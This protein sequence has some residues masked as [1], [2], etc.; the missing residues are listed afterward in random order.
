M[1]ES[2]ENVAVLAQFS[3]LMDELL[4]TGFQRGRFDPWEIDILLEIE[5]CALNDDAKRKALQAYENAVQAEMERG[6][7]RPMKFSEFLSARRPN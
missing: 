1:T 6:A 2:N 4:R 5:G 3:V 7:V